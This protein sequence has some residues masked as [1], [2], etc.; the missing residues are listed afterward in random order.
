MWPKCW[1]RNLGIE[2][3][4]TFMFGQSFFRHFGTGEIL[5]SRKNVL[6]LVSRRCDTKDILS[7][8]CYFKQ[9]I[10]MHLNDLSAVNCSWILRLWGTPCELVANC[11]IVRSCPLH[12]W[13]VHLCKNTDYLYLH[14]HLHNW[15]ERKN[16]ISYLKQF[17]SD[18]LGK[19]YNDHFFYMLLFVPWEQ[20]NL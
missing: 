17:Y 1:W 14:L 2:V 5:K 7:V 10:V 11:A 12:Q 18:I 6:E 16:I 19:I 9:S 4:Y 3:S 8:R 15:K 13:T 20:S